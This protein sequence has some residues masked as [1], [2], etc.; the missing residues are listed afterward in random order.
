MKVIVSHSRLS[1]VAPRGRHAAR[2][3]PALV[4]GGHNAPQYWHKRQ[5]DRY[6]MAMRAQEEEVEEEIHESENETESDTEVMSMAASLIERAQEVASS[7]VVDEDFKQVFVE[8]LQQELESLRIRAESA[9]KAA[10]AFEDTLKNTKDQFVRLTADF[11]NFRKRSQAE[12][13]AL[14][15]SVKGDALLELLPLVDNFELAK[16]QLKIETEGEQKIDDAYQGLYKQMVELFRG[17]GLEAVPGVGSPFDP[18]VHEAIM[19]EH[20]D[21]FDEGVVMEEFR[22]GFQFKE[23]LLRPAMVKVAYKE[24]APANSDEE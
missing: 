11:E 14:K 24:D 10:T 17:L 20:S 4:L 2:G 21:E 13:D 15:N 6:L 12:Q 5:S 7:G 8:E 19:R 16:Q 1:V 22:K 3:S 18:E 9:E 23:R